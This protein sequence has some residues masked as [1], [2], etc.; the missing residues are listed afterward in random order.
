[1]STFNQEVDSSV[2]PADAVLLPSEEEEFVFSDEVE[3]LTLMPHQVEHF[4]RLSRMLSYL[5]GVLDT[6]QTGGG[7]T[8][9]AMALS[10]YFGLSIIVV[11]PSTLRAVW[12]KLCKRYQVPLIETL[13]YESLRG[14]KDGGVSHPFLVRQG[15]IFYPSETFQLYV[16]K[17]VLLV[18]DECQKFKNGETATLRASHAL[19][20]LIVY[21]NLSSRILCL[22]ASPYDKIV[23]CSSLLK[24][25]GI[26]SRRT[27]YKYDRQT[28][29]YTLTG[30]REVIRFAD[31]FNPGLSHEM[32]GFSKRRGAI[33]KAC[34][35]YYVHIIKKVLSSE[36]DAPDTEFELNA[37]NGF[38]HLAP[39]EHNY[40]NISEARLRK[41]IQYK[42]G[43][44]GIGEV[45]LKDA[46]WAKITQALMG[47]ERSKL[48][49]LLRLTL[50]KL[51]E[52]KGNKIVIFVSY[53]NSMDY[54]LA[55]FTRR[56]V[57]AVMMN[58]QTSM[59]KRDQYVSAFQNPSTEVR[60]F[61]TSP[62]V[63]GVGLSLDDQYGY[64]ERTAYAIPNYRFIDLFQ[65]CGRIDRSKTKSQPY[66]R[67]VYGANST[68]G[69]VMDA[70]A[71]KTLTAREALARGDTVL[72]PGDFLNYNEDETDVVFLQ[73]ANPIY[74]E[75]LFRSQ[76][77]VNVQ[78]D[79][80]EVLRPVVLGE[81]S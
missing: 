2:I 1:M 26:I 7:K 12:K 62:V 60:V 54:L 72:F 5:H 57:S 73:D 8:Y 50:S 25:L 78:V 67:F 75:D 70:L 36:T 40:L 65:A 28:R 11:C 52:D 30:M 16:R 13:S 51:D 49:L 59:S 37:R 33:V 23:H 20:R 14:T 15:D 34:H 61:I 66:V 58:G 48:K 27:L 38:Y 81:T 32:S 24:V 18:F 4:N 53:I 35:E 74:W 63:G 29:E 55:E 10:L 71:R 45:D 21:E 6:T 46:D 3:Q 41:A 9:I 68:E 39:E 69:A 56:G 64:Y 44:D 19:S 77:I 42:E 43:T 79:A 31:R 22:S 76:P 47:L 17:G 80:Q